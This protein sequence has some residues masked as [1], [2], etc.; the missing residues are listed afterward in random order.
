MT[1]VNT[2]L[3]KYDSI[4]LPPQGRSIAY[5]LGCLEID[6]IQ[7]TRVS[8]TYRYRDD[9]GEKAVSVKDHDLAQGPL[10]IGREPENTLGLLS[11]G[12]SGPQA[13]QLA[14]WLSRKQAEIRLDPAGQ[15][16]YQHLGSNS[17]ANPWA[18]QAGGVTPE[19]VQAI[20][21]EAGSGAGFT[22]ENREGNPRDGNEDRGLAFAGKPLSDSDALKDLHRAVTE[23]I[24]PQTACHPGGS[25]LS[26][27][28]R[29]RDGHVACAL[30]GDSPIYVV[31]Q[32]TNGSVALF[33][34]GLP[35]NV[36][37]LKIRNAYNNAGLSLPLNMDAAL[38][39]LGSIDPSLAHEIRDPGN[40][41]HLAPIYRALGTMGSRSS[42]PEHTPDMFTIDPRSDCPAGYAFKGMLVCSDGVEGGVDNRAVQNALTKLFRQNP[43]PSPAA[44]AEAA[45]RAA[46]PYTRDNLTAMMLPATAQAGDL[47]AVADGNT[48]T[49]EVAELALQSLKRH[50]LSA[51]RA[52][53]DK[54]SEERYAVKPEKAPPDIARA[55]LQDFTMN[56]RAAHPQAEAS[57]VNGRVVIPSPPPALRSDLDQAIRL[58]KPQGHGRT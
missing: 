30:L 34:M 19:M 57:I 14:Q 56:L 45:V 11:A 47:V 26:I 5:A 58:Q 21:A 49:A 31:G 54:W 22:H 48:G 1:Q 8:V 28:M 51:Y 29:T 23:K 27:A 9:A 17:I 43:D 52:R 46:Q 53:V 42:G 44:I 32:H 39:G 3:N 38:Q 36:A 12:L 15:I 50:C 33:P 24:A 13:G 55:W 41:R 40:A 2:M 20:S 7:G 4:P 37:G 6:R 16:I 18:V 35:H 10:T 25:T